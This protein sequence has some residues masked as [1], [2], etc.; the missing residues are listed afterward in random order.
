MSNRTKTISLV[1]AAIAA[2][3]IAALLVWL[4][5]LEGTLGLFQW[6]STWHRNFT[7]IG[8]AGLLPLVLALTSL[9]RRK[10]ASRKIGR[11]FAFATLVFSFLALALAGGLFYYVYSSDHEHTAS[12]AAVRLVDPAKGISAAEGELRLSLS[13][14]P[15]YGRPL[16]SVDAHRSILRSVAAARPR[17][18]AFLI[19]GDNVETG[20]NDSSWQEELADL[21]LLG[22]MPV[23]SLMGNHD[24]LVGGQYHYL[25][26]FLPAGIKT[27]SKSPF[28]FAMSAGPAQI[29]VLELLWGVETFSQAQADWLEKTLSSLP[30]G[31][32]VIVLSHSFIYASG[33]TDE[34]GL[35]YYD[36]PGCIAKVAPILERH[37]VALVVSGHNHDMELL[38]K[39]GVTYVVIGAMGG[40][41]DPARSYSSPASLW[42][43]D[44]T[45]GRLDLDIGATGIG[46]AFKD[47]EGATLREEFIPAAK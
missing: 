34:H 18:D 9:L 11:L 15:H 30:A 19:L 44:G 7:L 5:S 14:D 36:N 4:F 1:A 16:S 46:L 47:K 27:P 33:Y 22:D 39:N 38:R 20:M 21:A 45:F 17:R 23:F 24:G 3:A 13:S 31:K 40:L 2:V 6:D 28:Y 42:F 25:N 35:D 26:Y 43:K 41:L 10:A 37:K 8:L 29:V 12:T 32:Q